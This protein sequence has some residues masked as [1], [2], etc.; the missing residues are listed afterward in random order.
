MKVLVLG[1]TQYIGHQVALALCAA[2]HAV[3]VFNRGLSPDA[4]PA[5][6]QR[7]RGDRDAGA[8]GLAALAGGR[9]DAC[10]DFSGYTPRQVLASSA[11]LRDA[12]GHFVYLSAVSVYGDPPEGPVTE[13]QPLLPPAD[14][15]VTEVNGQTYGPL[16]V[17]CEAIVQQ[18]FGARCALLRPQVVA[19]P[20]DP[21][22]RLSYWV[23][24]AGQ[25]GPM[26]APGDGSDELQVIDVA[27][28]ARFIVVACERALQGPFNLAGPRLSWAEFIAQ[29]GVADP[30]WVPADVIEAAQLGFGELPL[31]RRQ[32]GP[33]SSLMHVSAQRAL[34]H[35][36]ELS[37]MAQTLDRVRRWLAGGEG[38]APALSTERERGLLHRFH[39]HQQ[40]HGRGGV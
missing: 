6:V 10:V 22:D 8:A 23:R 12:V 28:V 14:D 2:G 36:L 25:P 20:R 15:R 3:S 33:R 11:L 39:R 40:L 27:D 29:L 38:P 26:L 19:G 32:G 35:G 1:G 37:P 5:G 7:L 30:V 17:R 18:A 21:V 4:L 34:Q 24:R 31:Y 16:K 9:W 13:D